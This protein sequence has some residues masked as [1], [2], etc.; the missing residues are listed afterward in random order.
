MERT[1]KDCDTSNRI[2]LIIELNRNHDHGREN[3]KSQRVNDKDCGLG[4]HQSPHVVTLLKSG[5][6]A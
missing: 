4:H 2:S 1:L 3:D 5:D 6:Q